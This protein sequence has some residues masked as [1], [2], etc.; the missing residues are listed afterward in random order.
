MVRRSGDAG[1]RRFISDTPPSKMRGLRKLDRNDMRE[2]CKESQDRLH[3]LRGWV[4][5][6]GLG[7]SGFTMTLPS[8][9]L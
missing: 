6:P 4:D 9:I 7:C 5:D 2:P 3:R 1:C 8:M